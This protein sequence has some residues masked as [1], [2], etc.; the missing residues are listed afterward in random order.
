M[1]KKYTSQAINE[2]ALKCAS[3]EG[4]FNYSI[5]N[6]FKTDASFFL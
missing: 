2:K 5:R 4:H 6:C 1:K 3:G